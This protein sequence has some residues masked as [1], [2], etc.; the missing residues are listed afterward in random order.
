[1]LGQ[2]FGELTVLKEG[3]KQKSGTR[4][5]YC[6]CSCGNTTLTRV[7][8][9]LKHRTTQCKG[10]KKRLLNEVYGDFIILARIE[11]SRNRAALKI[12]CINCKIIRVRR[13]YAVK[14]TAQCRC[15]LPKIEGKTGWVYNRTRRAAF[16][17][18]LEFTLSKQFFDL[19]IISNCYYCGIG[20][21][22]N[23]YHYV[24][25]NGVDRVDNTKGYIEDNVVACCNMCN[26]AKLNHTKEDFLGWAMRLYHHQSLKGLPL[27][28]GAPEQAKQAFD[29]AIG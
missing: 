25:I 5:F 12:Q 23:A 29:K 22:Q 24:K 15:R 16:E 17:R 1:M 10:H 9:L 18:N 2:K 11:T 19:L 20:P 6:L 26:T 8:R 28:A 14:N 13:S 3:P 27:Q 4:R 21:K 7:G